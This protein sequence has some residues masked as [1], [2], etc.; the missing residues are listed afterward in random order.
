MMSPLRVLPTLLLV[1]A[2]VVPSVARGQHA[3]AG[4]RPFGT[5]REQAAVQQEW[6]KQRLETFLPGLMRRESLQASR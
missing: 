5:L 6:L 2:T 3:D 4:R 1:S